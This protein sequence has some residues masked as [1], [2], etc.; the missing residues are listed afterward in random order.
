MLLATVILD[1]KNSKY[2]LCQNFSHPEL[3]IS[4]YSDQMYYIFANRLFLRWKPNKIENY[5]L[6]RINQTG[7]KLN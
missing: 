5:V 7:T 4:V 3:S 2:V 6:T 1:K